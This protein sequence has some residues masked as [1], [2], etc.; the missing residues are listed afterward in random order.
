M[1]SHLP[2]SRIGV[3]FEID[4]ASGYV[5]GEL[6]VKDQTEN[7]LHTYTLD[8]G[9]LANL[10]FSFI[11]DAQFN[12]LGA[13]EDKGIRLVTLTLT[14]D[15]GAT[16]HQE[17]IYYLLKESRLVKCENSLMTYMEALMMIPDIPNMEAWGLSDKNTRIAA[18]RQAYEDVGMLT[19]SKNLFSE[20]LLLA[21]TDTHRNIR[22]FG[23]LDFAALAG[24]TQYDLMRAQLL[25]AEYLLGGE[26][27]ESMRKQGIMSNSVG[28]S[29]MFF[30]TT[31]KL[32]NGISDRAYRCI[33][34]YIDRRVKI[35][36]G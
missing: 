20:E 11:V 8:A 9:D 7:V 18:L 34:R 13:G 28:E 27:A 29:T 22:M 32:D 1:E 36:Y 4:Q 25:H 31:F 26:K 21:N 30:R 23:P 33:S 2:G 12:Q 17:V 35:N 6:T 10:R 5:S 15:D 24:Q 3:G 19:L 14:D 16:D